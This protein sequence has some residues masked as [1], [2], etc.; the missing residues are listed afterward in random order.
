MNTLCIYTYSI[1]RCALGFGGISYKR[2]NCSGGG[3]ILSLADCQTV[4]T[5]SGVFDSMM[6]FIQNSAHANDEEQ[7]WQD[8]TYLVNEDLV[9]FLGCLHCLSTNGA[10]FISR[11]IA[12]NISELCRPKMLR[13][14][15]V[16]LKIFETRTGVMVKYFVVHTL[17]PFLEG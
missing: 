8:A 10:P 2:P 5:E 17:A 9:R 1:L 11:Y 7:A 6:E 4:V 15:P 16:L 13:C 14:I 3:L 12:I